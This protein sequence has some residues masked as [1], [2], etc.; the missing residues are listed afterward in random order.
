MY[1]AEQN[2][3]STALGL[4]VAGKTP[5]VSSFACLFEPELMIRSEWLSIHRLISNCSAHTLGFHQVKMARHKWSLEDLAFFRTLRESVVLYPSDA[6][7]T[8][9]LVKALADHYGLSYYAYHQ[10]EKANFV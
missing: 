9:K 8:E 1:V 6:V 5:Y 2:M 3:V 10:N 7:S 4:A